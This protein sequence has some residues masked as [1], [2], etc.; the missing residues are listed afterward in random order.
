MK[1]ID[2]LEVIIGIGFIGYML[3]NEVVK[4]II[5][6]RAIDKLFHRSTK[7]KKALRSQAEFLRIKTG[8]MRV[9]VLRANNGS[10]IASGLGP[11][12]STLIVESNNMGDEEQAEDEWSNQRVDDEYVESV[13][14]PI[15]SGEDI[16]LRTEDLADKSQLKDLYITRG[17][18]HTHIYKM[19]R[20][21]GALYYLSIKFGRDVETAYERDAVRIAINKMNRIIK[22]AA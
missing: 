16:F 21:D 6:N 19:M 5:K 22:N 2:A 4:D 13:I 7:V 3:F 20:L 10:A 8:A 15:D 17:V 1:N 14:Q 18:R 11:I 12:Y 9:S